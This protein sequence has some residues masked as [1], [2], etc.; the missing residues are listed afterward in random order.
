M[1]KLPADAAKLARRAM[2]YRERYITLPLRSFMPVVAVLWPR[3]KAAEF[4]D[5]AGE[6]PRLYRHHQPRSDDAMAGQW[7]MRTRQTV[8]VTVPSLVEHPDTVP[9]VIGRRAAWGKDSSRVAL[10]LASDAAEYEW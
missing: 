3:T 4:M 8:R 10:F 1:A 7:K 9:S 5:W 2:K 6:N